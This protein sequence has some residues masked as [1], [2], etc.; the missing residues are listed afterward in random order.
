MANNEEAKL[1][2]QQE[3]A[4]AG[5]E[6]SMDEVLK[7][8]TDPQPPLAQ[9]APSLLRATAPLPRAA[10]GGAVPWNAPTVQPS[11]ATQSIVT[12]EIER[13]LMTSDRLLKNQK[14][15]IINEEAHY[16]TTRTQIMNDYNAKVAKLDHD[17]KEALFQLNANHEQ[18]IAGI[19]R[20]I[21]KLTA[22]RE[23]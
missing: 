3:A 19:K 17:T 6:A 20:L 2:P 15:R 4:L 21:T 1:T 23:A 13:L 18:T 10:S 22:L 5:I 8:A 16:E 12:G 11:P 14:D 7:E 9:P